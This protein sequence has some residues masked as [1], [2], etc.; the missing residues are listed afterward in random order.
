MSETEKDREGKERERKE[1]E[2]RETEAEKELEIKKGNEKCEGKKER[3][4]EG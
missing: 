1:R 4:R 3:V 2:R